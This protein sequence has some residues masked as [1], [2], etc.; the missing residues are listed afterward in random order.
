MPTDAFPY[1][2]VA[3]VHDWLVSYRGGEKVLEAIAEMFPTVDIYTLLYKPGTI[4]P[5]LEQYPIKASFL[6]RLPASHKYYRYLLPLMPLAIERLD[7]KDYD[8]VISSSSCVAKGIIPGPRAR[9]ICYCLTTMRYAWDQYSN[10]FGNDW[11]QFLIFPWV[12]Y[13]RMWDVTSSARVDEFVADSR[14][15]GDRIRKYYRRESTVIAPFVDLDKYKLW[16]GPRDNYYLVASAHAPYKRLDLAIEA[17]KK[18]GRRLIVVGSGQDAAELQKLAGPGIEF[19]GQ[20][21]D[22]KLLELY[23]KA[24]AL[25][26]PGEEDFGIVPLEAMA[27]GTPVIAF[28]SGGAQET[29]S[30]PTTGMFFSPQTVDALTQAI[31]EFEQK[32]MSKI[33]PSNCRRQAENFSKENFQMQFRRLLKPVVTSMSSLNEAPYLMQ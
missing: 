13:L 5:K 25:L 18:L 32:N 20:V 23:Q 21:S 29:V 11:K 24:R 10:Y 28:D 19:A 16:E 31:L 17:C 6:N 33:E 30:A 22:E 7:L 2:R 1:K 8:L 26:F 9:H 12:H 14:F 4:G 15:V 3:L 27:C